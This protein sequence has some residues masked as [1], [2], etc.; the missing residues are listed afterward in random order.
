MVREFR[1]LEVALTLF[2]IEEDI[3]RIVLVDGPLRSAPKVGGHE[4]VVAGADVV[5]GFLRL[6]RSRLPPTGRRFKCRRDIGE[7]LHA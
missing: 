7:F 2:L 5:A 1:I 6:E 3:F 4:I